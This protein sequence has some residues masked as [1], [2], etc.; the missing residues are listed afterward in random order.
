MLLGIAQVHTNRGAEGIAELERALTLDPSLA[1][2]RALLGL[3]MLVNGRADETEAHVKEALRLSPHDPYASLWVGWETGAKLF[4]GYEE[5]A[6]ALYRRSI[7]LNRSNPF[8]HL[9]LAAAL[10]LLG[11]SEEA[12]KEAEIV[13]HGRTLKAIPLTGAA[14]FANFRQQSPETW[15]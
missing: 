5:E 3:A 11:R 13:L 12:R 6:V 8:A 1:E 4:P 10:Q 7:E 15:R 14:R 2:A 9:F